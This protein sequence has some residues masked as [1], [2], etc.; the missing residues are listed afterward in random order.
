MCSKYYDINT[1]EN[2]TKAAQKYSPL[3]TYHPILAVAVPVTI[4][5]A[6]A[7]LVAV[8]A[9][10]VERL[11]DAG[12]QREV[13]LARMSLEEGAGVDGGGFRSSTGYGRCDN[14][15]NGQSMHGAFHGLENQLRAEDFLVCGGLQLVR[16]V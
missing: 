1:K 7:P 16:R 11:E 10:K 6:E 14:C 8:V 13:G 5:L 9:A 2:R 4:A 15:Q 3:E 12:E